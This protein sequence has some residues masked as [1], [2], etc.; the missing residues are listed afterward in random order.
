MTG[1]MPSEQAVALPEEL[2]HPSR[3]GRVVSV[4]GGRVVAVLNCED[5][6]EASLQVGSIV[7]I[8]RPT[9]VVFGLVE[10]LTIPLLSHEA[11]GVEARLAEISVV[12]EIL[13]HD[14]ESAFRRGVS[15]MPGLDDIVRS[16]NSLDAEAIFAR[17]QRQ[18]IK[19]GTIH[20]DPT[21]SAHVKVDNLL[22]R[23]FAMVG[24]TGTGKSSALALL[25]QG[26]IN[27]NPNGHILLLDSHGEY[28]PAF[29]DQAEHLTID[30]LRLPHWLLEFD[31]LT[32]IL[33]GSERPGLATEISIL[34]QLVLKARL[35]YENGRHSAAGLTVDTP[36][37]YTMAELH[38]QLN[39]ELGLLNNQSS[40]GPLLKLKN[41]LVAVQDD[42]RYAFMFPN[43]VFLLDDLADIL[44]QLFRLPT[45]GRPICRLDLSGIS[46]EILN[47]VVSVV[48]RLA[49]SLAVSIGQR[50]PLLL[51]CEEAHRYAPQ[52][53]ALGFEPAK[54]SLARIAK[55][56]RKYGISLGLLSQ[57]PAELAVSIL[58]QCSTVFAFRM[59]STADQDVIQAALPDA[60]SALVGSLPLLSNGEAVVIGEGVA[61]PMRVRLTKLDPSRQPRSNSAR[62]SEAWQQEEPDERVLE[63][64]VN[65]WRGRATV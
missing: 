40:L 2:V 3:I 57:R 51:V 9:A 10:G 48:A 42:P 19:I 54:Q 34:R 14:V 33:F 5:A 35:A 37:P 47:V 61:V 65:A 27:A 31:E 16:T 36:T 11:G 52:D 24:A 20:Q 64:V 25:L 32:E 53:A 46:S 22:V 23:H 15:S 26:I 41:C 44:G 12:G 59:V 1:L 56:G 6:G 38:F 50:T 8:E 43:E 63:R 18:T 58:S 13:L 29:G 21:V 55:E 49:F 45:R 60:S 17:S 30:S 62:F 39:A 7:K 28:G 4:T